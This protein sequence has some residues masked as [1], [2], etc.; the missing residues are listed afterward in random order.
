VLRKWVLNMDAGYMESPTACMIQLIHHCRQIP[1][2]PTLRL[3]WVFFCFIQ[4]L[5]ADST[6]LHQIE[7]RSQRDGIHKTIDW[8]SELLPDPFANLRKATIGSVRSVCPHGRDRLP[9]DLFSWNLMFMNFRKI[10]RAN[11]SFV[12]ICFV[13]LYCIVYVVV[14]GT[15]F[16]T[17]KECHK[18]ESL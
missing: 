13:L 6:I 4:S 1:F 10:F 7:H 16:Y 9:L 11:W 8:Q 15:G 2:M 5:R 14:D 18:T 12:K 17:C 3:A